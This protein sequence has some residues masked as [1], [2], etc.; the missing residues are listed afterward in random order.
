MKAQEL[1][2]ATSNR[3]RLLLGALVLTA[4]G[5]C[6]AEAERLSPVSTT[7]ETGTTTTSSSTSSSSSSSTVTKK[8][9]I[10][11]RN[12]FGNVAKAGNL[13]MDG[14]FEWISPFSDQ[15][16][17]LSGSVQGYLS[18]Q[19]PT[20]VLGPRCRSGIKCAELQPNRVVVGLSVSSKGDPLAVSFWAHV[21]QGD[22]TGVQAALMSEDGSSDTVAIAAE[23]TQPDGGWCH[24]AGLVSE[25]ASVLY[26]YIQNGSETVVI[27]DDAVVE[28]AGADSN[29]VA[30]FPIA[31]PAAG[32]WTWVVEQARA[33]TKPRNPPPNEAVRRFR[34]LRT[35]GRSTL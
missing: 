4:A 20:V 17:W 33:L 19:L 27:V 30:A 15:Y 14:D 18:Y 24:F 23:S 35:K 25:R 22:C 11:Q 12:P 5:S 34:A 3:V 28:A 1:K 6:L 16:G 31:Q 9:T 21:E 26:L 2:A 10:L 32:D 7:G 8:R 13:L 29:S